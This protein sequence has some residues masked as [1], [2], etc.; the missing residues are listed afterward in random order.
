MTGAGRQDSTLPDLNWLPPNDSY[1]WVQLKSG[2]WLKGELKA[3][4]ESELEFDSKEL[5][6]LT[7]DWT[8]IRQLRC[9][10]TIDV[11]AVDGTTVS[12]PITVTPQQVVVGGASPRSFPRDQIQSLTPGGSKERNHWSGKVSLGLSLR[13]G[14]T[15]QID[16]N[17]RAHIQRRTPATRLSLDYVGNVSS[18]DG[19][20][21]AN[22]HRVNAE[23][24]QWVSPRSYLIMPAAEYFED[25]FQN[26]AYRVTV[27][28]GAGYDLIKGPKMEW[29]LTAG[30][31]YQQARFESVEQGE[32][33]DK[34]AA[35]FVLGSRFDWDITRH[36][37]LILEYRGQYTSRDVGETLHHGEGTLSLE[38][39]RRLDLDVSLIWD[40]ITNPKIGADGVEPK[41]DDFRLVVGLGA[42]L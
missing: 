15:E 29:N 24:D 26:L 12:G 16:Y 11:L 3:M 38:L 25:A 6:G 20:E 2:E 14:N 1:D 4:Q 33:T 28:V 21:N 35:A 30:P 41:Q 19:T 42:K 7:F 13:S 5:D 32:A 10:R 37:E 31:A 36:I 8:D 17:G 23:W 34:S 39:T 18:V 9:P 27:G 22:N 40:R